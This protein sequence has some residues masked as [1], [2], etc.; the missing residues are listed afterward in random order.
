MDSLTQLRRQVSVGV[1]ALLWINVAFIL[2]AGL[3]LADP[4]VWVVVTVAVVLA[5][6]PSVAWFSDPASE[7]TI[8][9][10]CMANAALVAL[11]V[12]Q[13]RLSP[14]QSDMHMYFF[15][16][17]A[18]SSAWLSVS[19]IMAFTAVV[20]L[21]HVLLFFLMPEA[22]FPAASGFGRVVMH[23]VIL[24]LEAGALIV[25][26]LKQVR[27]MRDAAAS[28]EAAE[29]ARLASLEL[30][31]RERQAALE[32]ADE[33][34]RLMEQADQRARQQLR[35][36]TA[37]FQTAIRQLADGR[38]D[39]ELT[40]PF[41]EEFE[42][43][44][45]DLNRMASRLSATLSSV[46]QTAGSLDEQMSELVRG[47]TELA[48]RTEQQS[49]TLEETAAALDEITANV[50]TATRRSDEARMAANAAND[51]AVRS[52]SVV[53][54]AEDAMRRIEESSGLIAN[55]ISVI[56]E[57]AFQTNLLALNAGVEAARAGEAGKGFAV[58][59]QEVR[60]LA[61]RS[62]TAAKEIK[63]LIQQSS[64]EVDNGVALV[65]QTG[66][67]LKGIGERVIQINRLIDDIAK[68][69]SEQSTG[70][71]QINSAVNQLDQMTQQNAAM[72]Q[73]STVASTSIA[74]QSDQL[75]KMI[76]Q[77]ALRDGSADH[78]G[79]APR[80]RAAG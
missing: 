29:A 13:F 73:Q 39:V 28:A 12:Y 8:L 52:A 57:I 23:A 7:T 49:A 58:V 27:S 30:E 11:L 54:E 67:T 68:S 72:V 19:G 42:A 50:S 3:F 78:Q 33:R 34:A 38:L 37:A 21:H 53:A 26:A 16:V 63:Q 17:L 1:I 71:S 75:R 64:S 45:L 76:A 4:T 65:R 79:Q 18:I 61:Q 80:L 32:A 51:S 22:V 24:L 59:A 41:A 44:R 35:E 43:L 55:I 62:A 10:S 9:T 60:E 66:E 25:L 5:A 77:F 6:V 74:G 70:L 20:A 48:R 40:E 47:T 56:D 69:A 14:L 36:A 31:A 15:A 2:V 46:S